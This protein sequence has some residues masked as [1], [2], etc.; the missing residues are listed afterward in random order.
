MENKNIINE[1]INRIKLLFSYDSS[2]TLNENLQLS[3]QSQLKSLFRADAAV[4]RTAAKELDTAM[5]SIKGGVTR[6]DG[7][8]LKNGDEIIKAVKAGKL[9]PAELG[10]INGALL[11]TS[12][13]P[14]V[15]TAV[16]QDVVGTSTFATKYG[17]K[18]EAEAISA[19]QAKGWTN[20]DAKAAIAEYKSSGKS[21][22]GGKSA[23]KGTGGNTTN[24]QGKGKGV[25]NTKPKKTRTKSGQGKIKAQPGKP[26]RW[27]QF[28]NRL[29]GLSR[30]KIFKLL[31][32]AGGL[33]LVYRWWT[34]EG[35]APFPDCIG[36]N[37]PEEDFEKMVNEGDGSV[38]ISDTG[39][40]A[41]DRAG[42]GKFYDDKKFVTGN[43]KYSGTWEEVTGTGV[44]IT[45]GG[46]QYTMSCEGVQDDEDDDDGG[47]GGG[48]TGGGGTTYKDCASFPY[49][50]G[51]KSE[52]IRKVQECLGISA[53]GKLGPNTETTLKNNGYSVPLTQAD[54]DKIMEKCGKG[55]DEEVKQTPDTYS[56]AEGI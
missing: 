21:F 31:L 19:L 40:A 53:D 8:I 46:T 49:S 25:N 12:T 5:A 29:V 16:I 47:G 17:T 24:T 51:C 34:D 6:V 54:Y 18:T 39:V 52:D 48:G 41:I 22:K 45:I 55:D 14:A 33:Y 11:K 2:K 7:V 36:K 43:G 15:K 1:E 35:S 26:T 44:V 38:L 23:G 37:I 13:N 56:S 3:E 30:T 10:K 32:A 4:A 9:A 20:A 28:K 27:Q 42:G 50:K